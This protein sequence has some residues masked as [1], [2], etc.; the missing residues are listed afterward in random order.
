MNERQYLHV[1]RAVLARPW[2]IDRE[3]IEWAAITDILAMRLAGQMLS[4]DDIEARIAAAA[5]G[6]GSRNGRRRETSVAVVPIYGTIV[7]RS[8]SMRTSGATSAEDIGAEFDAALASAEVDGIVLDVDSPGGQVQGI[9]ELADRI[10]AARGSKP[11]AAVANH[12]AL[13]AAYWLASAADEIVVTPSGKVG[14]IGIIA[15]HQDISEA[16]KQLG[17]RTTLLTKGRRKAEGNQFEPLT[18]DARASIEADLELYYGMF[19]TG[20]ARGRGVGV[21]TVRSDYGE[22]GTVMAKAALAAGMVDRIGSLEEEIHRVAR[23]AASG[24]PLRQASRAAADGSPYVVSVTVGE[25][26]SGNVARPVAP[27]GEA[28]DDAGAAPLAPVSDTGADEAG[29]PAGLT[30]AADAERVLLELEAFATRA[31]EVSGLRSAEGRALSPA[32]RERIRSVAQ[33]ASSLSAVLADLGSEPQAASPAPKRRG[34]EV[35]EA[36]LAG[37]YRI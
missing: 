36:A 12:E 27:A 25:E 17:V 8:G 37:G 9:P 32:T 5:A 3:S 11:I 31:G 20:V 15:A 29:S 13:S 33:Q 10:R 18:D 22:G 16:Q 34:L 35:F 4:A 24:E 6:H 30:F 28:S 1:V 23:A 26:M 2:A 14:S 21:D 19:T 7:P